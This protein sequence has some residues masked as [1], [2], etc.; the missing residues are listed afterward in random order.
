MSLENSF[1]EKGLVHH[2]LSS[3]KRGLTCHKKKL[4]LG[5]VYSLFEF[6]EKDLREI[7]VVPECSYH[8]MLDTSG[9]SF[10]S[11]CLRPFLS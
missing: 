5:S 10:Q 2:I 11:L 7:D 4:E 9:Q 1:L 3:Y 8:L 6:L